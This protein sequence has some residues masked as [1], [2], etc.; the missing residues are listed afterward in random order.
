MFTTST[1]L[2]TYLVSTTLAQN[3][4]GI[5]RPNYPSYEPPDN[6]NTCTVRPRGN[7]QDDSPNLLRAFADCGRNGHIIF[8]A[9]EKYTIKSKIIIQDLD[10]VK[11]DWCMFLA[12]P[13]ITKLELTDDSQLEN[14]KSIPT[15][16][17]GTNLV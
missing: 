11:V 7:Q 6:R 5:W 13:F 14:G 3:Q 2:L 4:F 10:D 15:R 16:H 9:G 8:S 12:V 17:T 1:L